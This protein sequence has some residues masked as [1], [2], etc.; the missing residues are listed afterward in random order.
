MPTLIKNCTIFQQGKLLPNR[1]VL[2]KDGK[3][4]A[5]SLAGKMRCEGAEPIDADG[6]L[7]SPG[8]VDLHIHGSGEYLIDDGPESLAQLCK[9]LPQYGVTGF[10]AG[11][12]PLPEGEDAEFLA[13][14]AGVKSDGAKI[15]GFHLEGPFLALTGAL[16]PEV[17]GKADKKRVDS[18]IAAA[19]PYPAIFSVSP[20]L[21]GITELI[22]LMVGKNTPVFITH[23]KAN[24]EQTQAAIEAGATHATHFYDV[25]YAPDEIDPGVRSCG[26]V[27]AILADS[28]VSV[29][30]ILD[31]E[32][33]DPVAVRMALACKGPRKVCLIT[34][35]NRGAGSVPGRYRFGSREITFAYQGAP[36]RLSEDSDPPNCIAGSGLTMDLAI[37]NAVKMLDVSASLAA[38]MAS[39]NPIHVLGLDSKKGYIK[40]GYDA[41][42]VLLSTELEVECTFVGGR[43]V[44]KK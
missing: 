29:D 19:K 24:V 39:T 21:E 36:A 26:A 40:E 1:D 2:L 9:L 6:N 15:L 10:L 35:A 23:T 31:G 4:A 38:G 7:L 20:E 44:Y 18:L 37:R 5:I 30:F 22:P 34:D 17:L 43:C 11:V 12:C 32:H 3:I 41:D 13:S 33:V 25:F 27:E 16:P 28:R 8:F 42:L 14:L